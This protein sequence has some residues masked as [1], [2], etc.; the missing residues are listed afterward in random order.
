MIFFYTFSCQKI[1]KRHVFSTMNLIFEKNYIWFVLIF[2]FVIVDSVL[3][4]MV[5]SNIAK[6]K[7]IISA[8]FSDR[9]NI[10]GISV[11]WII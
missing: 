3:Q 2:W 9:L 8:I 5:F 6:S 7:A 11:V 4:N 10:A 1:V